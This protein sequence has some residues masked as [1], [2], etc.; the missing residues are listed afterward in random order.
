MIGFIVGMFFVCTVMYFWI[1]FLMRNERM[2]IEGIPDGWELVRVGNVR[3]G[4]FHLD[5]NGHPVKWNSAVTSEYANYA[6]IRK[7]EKPKQFRPFASAAEFEPFRDRWIQRSGKHD[8]PETIPAG[9]FKVTAYNDH[10]YWTVD[11]SYTSYEQAFN[12]GKC[13]DD[14]TPFGIEV[15]E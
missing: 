6:I 2:T 8:T 11:G 12:D 15:T 9:C 7:I 10:H 13:F 1:S 4:E 3:H 14:G 5:G